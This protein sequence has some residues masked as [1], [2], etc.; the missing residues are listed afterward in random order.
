MSVLSPRAVLGTVLAAVV[1]T[2]AAVAVANPAQADVVAH[3]GKQ[4]VSDSSSRKVLPLSCLDGTVVLGGGAE[5]DDGSDHVHVTGWMPIPDEPGL[6]H[7]NSIV[8]YG[9]E[10][11]GGFAGNWDLDTHALCGVAPAGLE[12]VTVHS[13]TGSSTTR[14]AIAACPGTTR[15]VGTGGRVSDGAGEV[16]LTAI[17]PAADLRSLTVSAHEDADGFAGSWSVSAYAVCADELPDH[18]LV[19]A[20]SASDATDEKSVA[21]L[22]PADTEMH[23]TGFV[24]FGQGG[25]ILLTSVL[26]MEDWVGSTVEAIE[27][28]PGTTGRWAVRAYAICASD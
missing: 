28:A 25:H 14:T 16:L 19:V 20:D 12:Y 6:K 7:P 9:E 23:G 3:L 8:A 26:V 24:V 18:Q 21:A 1:V 11:D 27:A 15:L 17:Q 10:G 2:A 22:C 13:G 5:V 4:S